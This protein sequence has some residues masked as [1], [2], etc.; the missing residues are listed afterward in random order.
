[1]DTLERL[2]DLELLQISKE[3]NDDTIPEDALTRVVTSELMGIDLKE[4]TIVH[5][6][7]TAVQILKEMSLRFKVYSPHVNNIQTQIN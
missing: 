5:L 1:M 6:L 4:V 7:G 2:T 3:L